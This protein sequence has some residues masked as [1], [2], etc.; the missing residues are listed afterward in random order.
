MWVVRYKRPTIRIKWTTDDDD[1]D[2]RQ[3]D[4]ITMQVSRK[5]DFDHIVTSTSRW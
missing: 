1:D 5:F 2:G 3:R 4:S